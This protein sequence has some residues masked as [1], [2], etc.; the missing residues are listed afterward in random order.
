[1]SDRSVGST[2]VLPEGLPSESKITLE[3]KN[4]TEIV[5][6]QSLFLTSDFSLPSLEP[7]GVL[8]PDGSPSSST[9]ND[10]ASVAGAH[11]VGELPVPPAS[12]AELLED[13][14]SELGNVRYSLVGPVPGQV[15]EWPHGELPLTWRPVWAIKM[16]KCRKGQAVFLRESLDDA[17]PCAGVAGTPR[18]VRTWKKLIWYRRRRITPPALPTLRKLWAEFRKVA[19]NV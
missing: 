14:K 3:A 9:G 12:A 8:D 13:M 10:G 4:G 6:S 16:V 19:R 1:M 11:V 17:S 7:A 2:F 15:V 5:A 18:E